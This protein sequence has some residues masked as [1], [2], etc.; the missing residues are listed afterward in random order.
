MKTNAP[1]KSAFVHSDEM[2]LLAYRGDPFAVVG[3]RKAKR[4]YTI[5]AGKKRRVIVVRPCWHVY[6]Q[7]SKPR[8]DKIIV[9]NTNL[10]RDV[11]MR[12][13]QRQ[14]RTRGFVRNM[15]LQYYRRAFLIVA[16]ND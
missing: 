4:S 3:V 11:V 13:T 12:R 7:F 1:S 14:L 2:S 10:V 9:L 15:A 5:R 16:K 6:I 8:L